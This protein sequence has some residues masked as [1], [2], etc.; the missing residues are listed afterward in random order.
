MFYHVLIKCRVGG[1]EESVI[2][3]AL[4]VATA[5]SHDCVFIIIIIFSRG[6]AQYVQ[7][8]HNSVQIES[9]NIISLYKYA[10]IQRWNNISEK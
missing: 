4:W 9:E 8:S 5:C 6:K 10:E 7:K 2:R 3:I 1:I